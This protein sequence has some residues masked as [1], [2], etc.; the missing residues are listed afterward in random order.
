MDPWADT[1]K[2]LPPSVTP[3]PRLSFQGSF[4]QLHALRAIRNPSLKLF[5]SV[6]GWTESHGFSDMCASEEKR[7]RG[8]KS[9]VRFLDT[10]EF[11]GIGE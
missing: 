10:Y 3:L 9:M 1:D 7:Q 5:I 6:G 11:D 2:P 4:H 8:V